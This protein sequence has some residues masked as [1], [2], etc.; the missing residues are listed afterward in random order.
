[1]TYYHPLWTPPDSSD[2]AGG[3]AAVERALAAGHA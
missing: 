1:M 3:R 2:L